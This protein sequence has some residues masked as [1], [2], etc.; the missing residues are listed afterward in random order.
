M[1]SMSNVQA[2]VDWKVQ[3]AL[4]ETQAQPSTILNRSRSQSKHKTFT[5]VPP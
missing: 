2:F 1:L 5:D 3:K 4:L